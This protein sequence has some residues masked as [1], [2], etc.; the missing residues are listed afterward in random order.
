MCP[1]IQLWKMNVNIPAVVRISNENNRLFFTDTRRAV[2]VAI[3]RCNS[4]CC[5]LWRSLLHL[6]LSVMVKC[7]QTSLLIH[8]TSCNKSNKLYSLVIKRWVF[9]ATQNCSI[10]RW[11][12]INLIKKSKSCGILMNYGTL[13]QTYATGTVIAHAYICGY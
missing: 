11:Q 5:V 10:V 9:Q 6:V 1:M 4:L 3:L 12:H 8:H 13:H 7:C 2:R